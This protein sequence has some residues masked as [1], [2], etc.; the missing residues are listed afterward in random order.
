[1]AIRDPHPFRRRLT[2]LLRRE[3][4]VVVILVAFAMTAMLAFSAL[5]ID[6]GNAFVHR[7]ALQIAADAAALAAS[8]DLLEPVEARLV[9]R[10][11]VALN[12][13]DVRTDGD[14]DRA[15]L[16]ADDADTDCMTITTPY[17]GDSSKIEVRLRQ[18]VST[19]M[20]DVVGVSSVDVS[21]R[22]V[23]SLGVI[24]T[25]PT[26]IPGT[27]TTVTTPPRTEQVPVGDSFIFAM[28]RGC[29]A[30]QGAGP[31]NTFEGT[32]WTNGTASFPATTSGTLLTFSNNP[33]SNCPKNQVPPD[34]P[35]GTWGKV[36][37]KP[38]RDWPVPPPKITD[39]RG[40]EIPGDATAGRPAFVD[41]VPCTY[42]KDATGNTWTVTET[43][44]LQPGLYCSDGTIMLKGTALSLDKVGFVAPDIN[45]QSK[46]SRFSG[47]PLVHEQYGGLLLYAWGAGGIKNTASNTGWY[48]SI[49][50]PL[51]NAQVSG[52]GSDLLRGYVQAN[53][54]SITGSGGRFKGLGPDFGGE[55]I[56]H[57]GTTTTITEPATTIPGTTEPGDPG[58]EE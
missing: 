48:G 58:L 32:V 46:D 35:L 25:D 29:A 22:A 19:L 45:W 6:L 47:T 36:S 54:V 5:V 33:P 12:F 57:P 30:A 14:G 40:R 51:G 41:G 10:K 20:A 4:G 31:N 21:A 7:R 18:R 17:N 2:R 37:Q 16:C 28:D 52:K 34:G 55:I 13:G 50:A 24:T 8:Q 26:V 9:A 1:M 11:Y 53:T 15:A 49:H 56:T 27:T 38:P 44:N 42:G 3:D 39:A 43:L 23:A